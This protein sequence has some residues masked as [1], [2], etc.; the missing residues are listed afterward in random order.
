VDEPFE[1][2]AANLA[3]GRVEPP[4]QSGP[5]SAVAAL[6]RCQDDLEVL[7]MQRI[8][9]PGDRWSGQISLP[10]G[11]HQAEDPDLFAT[12][13]RETREEVGVD[14][15]EDARLLGHLPPLA[16]K[17][18][19]RVLALRIVPYVFAEVRRVRPTPGVEAASVF[20][21]PLGRALRGELDHVHA[22]EH[23]GAQLE[24]PAWRHGAHVIWGLTHE[25]LSSLARRGRLLDGGS[26]NPDQAEPD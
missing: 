18:R 4:P 2:L 22:F 5:R 14:L 10:G 24:L 9:R 3:A 23:R 26:R 7:L 11:H 6:L 19:G 25:I 15:A 8:E 17:A 21:F 13:L 12:S 16:A 20:W 1:R